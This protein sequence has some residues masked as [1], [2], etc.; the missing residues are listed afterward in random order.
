MFSTRRQSPAARVLSMRKI[1]P[2]R[3]VLQQRF[4]STQIYTGA[5]QPYLVCL[6]SCLDP[7]P[8][9]YQALYSYHKQQKL[10]R[11]DVSYLTAT[12]ASLAARA[13][14]SAQE[15]TPG[16]RAS[17]CLFMSS[18]TSNPRREFLFPKASFSPFGPSRSTEASHP[19][20]YNQELT[21]LRGFI[22]KPHD[23]LKYQ[24]WKESTACT[25]FS[26]AFGYM[27]DQQ[28]SDILDH[29]R[30]RVLLYWIQSD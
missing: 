25:I 17:T 14:M 16:Q 18:M 24:R 7:S 28:N 4:K 6:P 3:H 5:A 22:S 19:C 2:Q 12:T 27:A 10:S 15:T 20:R 13:T 9:F 1:Y 29:A 11:F 21:T 26:R 30:F 23:A 8:Q